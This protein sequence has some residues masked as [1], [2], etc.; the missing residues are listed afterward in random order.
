[1]RSIKLGEQLVE[2]PD[3]KDPC[4]IDPVNHESIVAFQVKHVAFLVGECSSMPR[5]ALR[6]FHLSDVAEQ[7]GD[8]QKY[9]TYPQS[10]A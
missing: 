2:S 1:M 6:A 4:H 8:H 7:D 10:L 9:D 3:R 5:T